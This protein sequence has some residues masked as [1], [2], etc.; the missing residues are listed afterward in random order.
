MPK[1][2]GLEE[3]VSYLSDASWKWNKMGRT[4][5]LMVPLLTTEGR[6][7]GFTAALVKLHGLKMSWDYP[8]HQ[9]MENSYPVYLDRGTY[10][11]RINLT[12]FNIAI[13]H[14]MIFDI[15]IYPLVI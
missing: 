13:A 5:F 2:V 9:A 11:D 15:C 10:H 6:G 3:T 7:R 1:S 8:I 4:Q 12:I 14:D